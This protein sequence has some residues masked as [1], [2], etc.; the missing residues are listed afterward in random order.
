MFII[1]TNRFPV[2]NPA[3]LVRHEGQDGARLHASDLVSAIWVP[4]RSPGNLVAG[5]CRST[6]RKSSQTVQE[7]R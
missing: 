2:C 7:A 1:T 5:Y 6:A 3:M 4:G